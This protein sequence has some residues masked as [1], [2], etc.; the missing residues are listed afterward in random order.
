VTIKGWY[1]EIVI[2]SRFGLLEH[3]TRLG[4][5]GL[6]EGER[7][8]MFEQLDAARI[9]KSRPMVVHDVGV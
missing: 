1:N 2:A 9:T 3:K 6:I 8:M 7:T 4:N 5:F